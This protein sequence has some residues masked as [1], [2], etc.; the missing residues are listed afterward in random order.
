MSGHFDRRATL[1]PFLSAALDPIVR[2]LRP[3][4]TYLLVA[5]VSRSTSR[6]EVLLS[7]VWTQIL[8]KSVFDEEP[9]E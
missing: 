9:C 5:L 1:G 3:T 8:V 7:I 2:K 4:R 6:Q